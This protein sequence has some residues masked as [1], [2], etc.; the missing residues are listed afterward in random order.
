MI[1]YKRKCLRCKVDKPA[2]D[3]RV[4]EVFKRVCK[5]C[6]QAEAKVEAKARYALVAE[7]K[8]AYEKQER[9][10]NLAR[11][12]AEIKV[13]AEFAEKMEVV[14][15]VLFDWRVNSINAAL[16][17]GSKKQAQGIRAVLT[18]YRAFTRSNRNELLR[19]NRVLDVVGDNRI[20]ET[21]KAIAGRVERQQRA[22]W[23]LRYAVID[24]AEDRSE[25]RYVAQHYNDLGTSFKV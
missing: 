14:N 19:L 12:A 20:A 7:M 1:V 6:R 24:I 10:R 8:R 2:A 5:A 11:L 13:N 22:V 16:Y 18:E 25:W 3:F 4:K 23:A 21:R 9:E 15:Q 17:K